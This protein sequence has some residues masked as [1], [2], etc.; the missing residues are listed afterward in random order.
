MTDLRWHG[1]GA[2]VFALCV[3]CLISAVSPRHATAQESVREIGSDKILL[4]DKEYF[5]DSTGI[6]LR[7]HPAR[8]TNQ[9][10]LF[11][12]HPWESPELN[13]FSVLEHGGKFRMWYECY[14][15]E[16]GDRRDSGR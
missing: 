12:E 5:A 9:P 7:P 1:L 6:R 16:G 4:I 3:G 14:D 13:W 15:V 10:I 8:K 2:A 11:A